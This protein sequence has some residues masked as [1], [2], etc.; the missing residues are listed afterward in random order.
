VTVAENCCESPTRTVAVAGVIVT[1]GVT[2][3]PTQPRATTHRTA[4]NVVA[5]L[6]RRGMEFPIEKPP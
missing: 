1:V 5:T 2:I 6:G 4:K 3:A